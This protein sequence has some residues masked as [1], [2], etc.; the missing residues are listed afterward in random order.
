MKRLVPILRRWCED[1]E[2]DAERVQKL[3][4]EAVENRR[5][6]KKT[7]IDGETRRI[8]VNQYAKNPRPTAD[9]ISVMARSFDLDRAALSAWFQN[10][11]PLQS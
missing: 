8:L 3:T 10:F 4:S 7:T 11:N 5:R 6:A 9:Q 1:I 2:K